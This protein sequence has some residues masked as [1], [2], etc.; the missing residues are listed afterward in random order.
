[1]YHTLK[2]KTENQESEGLVYGK[3]YRK[4]NYEKL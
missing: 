4:S 1:M 3:L 2:Y